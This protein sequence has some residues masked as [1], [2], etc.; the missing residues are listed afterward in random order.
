MARRSCSDTR[1]YAFGIGGVV[2]DEFREGKC[3]YVIQHDRQIA[4]LHA[5]HPGPKGLLNLQWAMAAYLANERQ[6]WIDLPLGAELDEYGGP[7]L[8]KDVPVRKG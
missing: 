2:A 5:P 8:D 6:A 7:R 4:N 3:V 1:R